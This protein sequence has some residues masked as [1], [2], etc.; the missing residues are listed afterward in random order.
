VTARPTHLLRNK[1]QVVPTTD[2]GISLFCRYIR[3][4][5][6]PPPPIGS[7]ELRFPDLSVTRNGLDPENSPHDA[8]WSTEKEAWSKP[9]FYFPEARVIGFTVG[10][11]PKTSNPGNNSPRTFHFAVE[12]VPY[13]DLY[14]HCEI[15]VYVDGEEGAVERENEIPTT[16]KKLVRQKIADAVFKAGTIWEAGQP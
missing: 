14:P 8:R 7:L 13:E 6:T 9:P 11:V 15:K 4:L 2:D 3:P 12:H 5:P 1:R 16:V 10:D